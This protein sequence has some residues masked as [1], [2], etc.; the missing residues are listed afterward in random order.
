MHTQSNYTTIRMAKSST[1]RTPNAH[2]NVEQ[3]EIAVIVGRNAKWY[4]QFG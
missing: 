3:Q 2:K 4:S 1:A